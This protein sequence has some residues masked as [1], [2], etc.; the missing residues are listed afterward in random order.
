VT[1]LTRFLA[2]LD[3]LAGRWTLRR[4]EATCRGAGTWFSA[5]TIERYSMRFHGEPYH[6]R[7]RIA[8]VVSSVCPLDSE[9]GAFFQVV[10]FD[11][12]ERLVWSVDEE[13]PSLDAARAAAA[14]LTGGAS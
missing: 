13:L 12:C 10:R 5:D 14:R 7:G 3:T 11:P 1:R 6:G 4:I 8:F 9:H 2:W